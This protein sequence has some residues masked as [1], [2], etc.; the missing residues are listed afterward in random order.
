MYNNI[1]AQ[2]KIN[3]RKKDLFMKLSREYLREVSFPVGG[4]GAGCIGV[5]GNGRLTDWEIFNEAGKGRENGCSHFAVRAERNGKVE[6]ARI[7]AGDL[8]GDLAGRPEGPGAMFYGFGWGPDEETLCGLPHFRNCE[9]N[10][11]FPAAEKGA[12]ELFR[13]NRNKPLSYRAETMK[14]RDELD[15]LL[16]GPEAK[17]SVN[18]GRAAAALRRL[19]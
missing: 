6:A 19:R 16:A 9:F 13:N 14:F 11:E 8:V 1:T 5:A 4:I 15:A 2:K 7:L 18:A 17:S 10:G 12:S 3:P